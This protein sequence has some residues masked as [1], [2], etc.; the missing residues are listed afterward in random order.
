[1]N[2]R[3]PP[4]SP[5]QRLCPFWDSCSLAQNPPEWAAGGGFGQACVKVMI[6]VDGFPFQIIA[7]AFYSHDVDAHRVRRAFHPDPGFEERKPLGAVQQT[8][9]WRV[10]PTPSL[11]VFG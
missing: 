2:F 5:L 10:H 11:C 7:G 3:G 1:M 6:I 4:F 8:C 9:A